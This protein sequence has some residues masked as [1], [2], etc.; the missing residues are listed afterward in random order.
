MIYTTMTSTRDHL[1]RNGLA[2]P[3]KDKSYT[4]QGDSTKKQRYKQK[5]NI[6]L[7]NSR[8]VRKAGYVISC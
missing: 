8:K 4:I 1:C 6:E 3:E 5:L 2:R 7:K